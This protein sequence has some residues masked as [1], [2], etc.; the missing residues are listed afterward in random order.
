MV[1]TICS[2]WGSCTCRCVKWEI[3]KP[4]DKGAINW[5]PMNLTVLLSVNAFRP[6]R[7]NPNRTRNPCRRCNKS[8]HTAVLRRW[9]VFVHLNGPEC[10]RP[11]IRSGC[12]ANMSTIAAPNCRTYN[13]DTIMLF[14]VLP[15]AT[16]THWTFR[17]SHW[18]RRHRI[19]LCTHWNGHTRR[20]SCRRIQ[21]CRG[22]I[23]LHRLNK[24][25]AAEAHTRL[26]VADTAGTRFV[27]A[28]YALGPSDVKL[29]YL[30]FVCR[31]MSI[32][33]VAFWRKINFYF[34]TQPTM[35]FLSRS[36]TFPFNCVVRH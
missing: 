19:L 18:M 9:Y 21:F 22:R 13:T 24:W 2:C 29:F 27:S 4:R 6:A 30:L 14:V 28:C 17:G 34:D 8:F 5:V 20:S 7:S 3:I 26:M 12:N 31:K 10:V 23:Q 33:L 16:R 36:L 25:Y 32:F 1:A 35:L 11:C 15:L